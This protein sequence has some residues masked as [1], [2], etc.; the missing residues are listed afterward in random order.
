MNDI[1][2]SRCSIRFDRAFGRRVSIFC[3]AAIFIFVKHKNA[4]GW[5]DAKWAMALAIP[6]DDKFNLS[7]I[8]LIYR[9]I[10]WM[11]SICRFTRSPRRR[12]YIAML[13]FRILRYAC[14]T[15]FS[16]SWLDF[17]DFS[18]CHRQKA[19]YCFDTFRFGDALSR[20]ATPRYLPPLS[21]VAFHR[22]SRRL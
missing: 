2:L 8:L 3:L 1:D 12:L 22:P 19:P 7:T 20:K 16:M 17:A 10:S 4:I 15:L 9:A 11:P 13:G 18:D 5:S 21:K 14:N 6:R